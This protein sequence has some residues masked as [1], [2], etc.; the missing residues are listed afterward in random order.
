[1]SLEELIQGVL[2][3]E[4]I[5]GSIAEILGSLKVQR[6]GG[7]LQQWEVLSSGGELKRKEYH[8]METAQA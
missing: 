8:E 1:M 5:W 2:Q 4:G 3:E 6:A 7:G